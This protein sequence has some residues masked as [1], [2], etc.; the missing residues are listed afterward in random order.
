VAGTA[1]SGTTWLAALLASGGRCRVLFE[2]FHTRKVPAYRGFH[3]F[4]Y[5][6]PGEEND[7]LLS[8]AREVMT[9]GIR[10]RW[11]DRHAEVLRPN[12]RLIKEIRANL[13][14]KWLHDRFPEVPILLILRHPCA[15]VASR[16]QLGWATDSDIESFL[17]QPKLVADFLDRRMDLVRRA[18]TDA[19]KHALVWCLSYL[20]PLTQF[21][22]GEVERVYYEDLCLRPEIEL[23]RLYRT[24]GL[25]QD[26]AVLDTAD[27]PSLTS[28]SRSAVV[29]GEDRISRWRKLLPARDAEA[30][31]SLVESFGLGGLYG[32][33]ELP[34]QAGRERE[35][36]PPSREG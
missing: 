4:Q 19:E 36:G 5:M 24:L 10:N 13:L 20:V 23:P 29:T 7:H 9:G 18:T 34:R 11:I 27:R 2:P 6:R 35:P 28:R 3:Y 25:S 8:F 14:L 33:S 21:A 30:V 32:D 26:E 12:R 16:L 17:A 22:P 15:V 31:I 1:R